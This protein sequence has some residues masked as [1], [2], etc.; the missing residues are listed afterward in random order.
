MITLH[1]VDGDNA[2]GDATVVAVF[3]VGVVPAARLLDRVRLGRG[4]VV[5]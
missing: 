2:I 1:A 3:A 5:A 4:I